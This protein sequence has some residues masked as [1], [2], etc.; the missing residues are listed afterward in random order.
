V[1]NIS[2]SEAV[3]LNNNNFISKV[4]TFSQI[5]SS[6]RPNK[7]FNPVDNPPNIPSL[8]TIVD[9]SSFLDLYLTNN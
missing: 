1:E 9:P 8:N 4:H 6:D 7:H 2:F 5:A 3:H